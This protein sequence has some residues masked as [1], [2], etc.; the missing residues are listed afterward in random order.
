MQ[1]CIL[2]QV[3]TYLCHD[4]VSNSSTTLYISMCIVYSEHLTTSLSPVAGDGGEVQLQGSLHLAADDGAQ[5][6][7][8]GGLVTCYLSP[9]Y[10][11]QCCYLSPCYLSL[12]YVLIAMLLLITTAGGAARGGPHPPPLPPRLGRGAGALQL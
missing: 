3:S 11:S 12:S 9:S 10:L 5:H 7:H 4:F 2:T 1:L 8:P 6:G